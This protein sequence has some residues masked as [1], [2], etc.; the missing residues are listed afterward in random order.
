M[1]EGQ[2]ERVAD[3]LR[4][5]LRRAVGSQ[6]VFPL[7]RAPARCLSPPERL[8]RLRLAARARTTS[9]SRAHTPRCSRRRGSSPRQD[10]DA[11][12]AALDQVQR[13]LG[14]GTFPFADGDEDIHM[15]IERRVTE[16]AGPVGG[17]LHTARSRND[18]VATDVAMFVR[19]H[20]F[21]AATGVFG[22]SRH[23]GRAC[24]GPS[25]LAD[26]R[27]HA[28]AARAARVS[29]P[30][31]ARLRVDARARPRALSTRSLS[32]RGRCRSAPA[33]SPASTS[34]PTDELV[35]RRARLLE[36]RGELDRRR[37]EPRLRARLPGG[38]RRCARPISRVSA[39]R[40]CC[41]PAR[42][43]GSARSPTRG[44]RARRSCPRRRT[45]T[46]PSCCAPRRRGSSAHLVGAPRRDARAAADLQQGHAGGQGASVRR[47]RHA[48][49][50]PRCGAGD[51]GVDLV[52]A[53]AACG[54]GV[55][56]VPGGDRHRGSARPARHAVPRGPRGRRRAR[57]G[58][59]RVRASRCRSCRGT[60]WRP[61]RRCSTTSSTPCSA[62]GRGSRA[63]CRR[64]ARASRA[65]ASS[66]RWLAKRC[67]CS[68]AG[69]LR[70]AGARGR[71]LA[72]RVRRLARRLL[73]RDRRDRG[74]PRLRAGRALR[75]SGSR[76]G[77]GRCSG[78]QG[79]RTCTARTGSTRC[80]TR[81]ASPRA[82]GRRC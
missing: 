43:S 5:V 38:G 28:P 69:I 32:R 60:S 62:S 35:A 49:A 2:V 64:E 14:D 30:P 7:R 37:L 54:G 79:T 67:G 9:S 77:P 1:S 3:A 12:H 52:P 27:L 82:W 47:R 76:R 24:R 19:A 58:G 11:L 72:G 45:P 75:S 16:I 44:P 33:R 41:G 66:S 68:E 78:R 15:A 4:A 17:K 59:D 81:S 57:A 63:R 34:I 48:R 46:R 74:L 70:A 80:S 13:E 61:R 18:Q 23:A 73:W 31:P 20:A 36:R 25:R 21:E 50:V 29:E 42:S 40:S 55:R 56:R 71:A 53:R 65:S 8:D 26:A 10:R 39:P 6:R 22:F 51:D